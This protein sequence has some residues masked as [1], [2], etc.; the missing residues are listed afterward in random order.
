MTPKYWP[1]ALVASVFAIGH[2]W[3]AFNTYL[4]AEDSAQTRGKLTAEHEHGVFEYR[5]EVDSKVFTGNDQKNREI[6]RTPQYESIQVGSEVVV[7][8]VRHWPA[9]S[10]LQTPTAFGSSRVLTTLCVIVGWVWV[11][12][13]TLTKKE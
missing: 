1:I 3:G 7:Y 13:N 6:W 2:L 12:K 8:Y 5:Y 9:I 4:L 11:L 10:S